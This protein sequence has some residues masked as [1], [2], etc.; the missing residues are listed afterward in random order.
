M[1]R[2]NRHDV[3]DSGES[4]ETYVGRWSRLVGREFLA[5]LTVPAGSRWL[6]VGCGTGELARVILEAAD[7][8]AAVGVDPSVS[9]VGFA[10]QHTPDRRASF[11]VG[12]AQALPFETA[13]FD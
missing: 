3:W 13:S 12:D 7:P 11:G 4:Y 10:R 8:E 5:W 1:S 9:Y 6:D 2:P